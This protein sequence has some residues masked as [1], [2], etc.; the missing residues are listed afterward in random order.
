MSDVE[1]VKQ[2]LLGIITSV[3]NVHGAAQQL[4]DTYAQA[5]AT[6]NSLTYGSTL[7]QVEEAAQT[8]SRAANFVTEAEGKSEEVRFAVESVVRAL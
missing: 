4:S 5:V 2:G 3:E 6:F 8:I 1:S 7:W